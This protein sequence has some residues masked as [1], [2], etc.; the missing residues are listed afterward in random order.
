M[1]GEQLQLS[2]VDRPEI[3]EELTPLLKRDDCALAISIS[4][5]KDSQ[6]Q[7]NWLSHL[8]K[9]YGWKAKMFCIHSDRELYMIGQCIEFQYCNE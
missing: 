1:F 2:I 5:G 3:P 6:A 8:H 9:K 4:G 7:L